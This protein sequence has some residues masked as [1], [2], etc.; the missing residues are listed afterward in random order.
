[1]GKRGD[2]FQTFPKLHN[3]PELD[4]LL[5]GLHTEASFLRHS[6]EHRVHISLPQVMDE[7]E[8]DA[9]IRYGTH[10]SPNKAVEFIHMKLDD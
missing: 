1:M 3:P 4:T 6:A 5:K 9:A 7:E 2:F 10:A 8:I